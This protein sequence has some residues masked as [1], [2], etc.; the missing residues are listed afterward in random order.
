MCATSS[1]KA[2]L[3]RLGLKPR[4]SLGQHFLIHPHQAERIALALDLQAGDW[5]VEIGGG[6]GALTR[7]LAAIPQHL[8]VLE[9]DPALAAYL[10]GELFHGHPRVQIVCADVLDFDFAALARE[11]AR[12]LK[13]AGNLPYQITSPLLFKLAQE[14]G[15]LARAV[16]MMQAEVGERLLAR[17]GTRD[18]GILTVMVQYHFT[19]R[20]LFSVGPAN[21][22][23]PPRVDSVVAA[24][25]PARPEPAAA[26]PELFLKVV[27]SAFSQRRKTLRNTLVAQAAT[28]GVT[29]AA[30]AE[31]LKELD[32]DPGRRGETLS[33]TQFTELSNRL[34]AARGRGGG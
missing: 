7:W 9:M 34:A 13:V 4:K 1:P 2:L 27:K 28:L 20:R 16:L 24:F 10:E 25:E 22:H 3:A 15:A 17:P 31:A 30:A 18:Y 33:V 32:I 26:D 14:K 23:P 8:V 11:A 12:P 6:L 5:V 19:V 29:A 21:F